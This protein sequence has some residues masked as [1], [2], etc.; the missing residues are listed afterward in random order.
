MNEIWNTSN[1][2]EIVNFNLQSSYQAEKW[3]LGK[4]KKLFLKIFFKN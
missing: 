2:V 4:F 1:Y 3:M